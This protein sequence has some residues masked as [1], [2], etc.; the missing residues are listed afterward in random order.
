MKIFGSG[1]WWIA[2]HREDAEI[3]LY[4]TPN[5]RTLGQATLD[6]YIPLLV[7]DSWEHSWYIDYRSDKNRYLQ[8]LWKQF[9]WEFAIENLKR[10]KGRDEKWTV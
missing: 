8:C 4:E 1:W 2:W 7:A 6:V 10:A 9:N 5:A 3:R